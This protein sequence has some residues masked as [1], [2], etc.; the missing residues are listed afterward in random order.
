MIP[1]AETMAVTVAAGAGPGVAVG[2][3]GRFSVSCRL[4]PALCRKRATPGRRCPHAGRGL[5]P[6]LSGPGQSMMAINFSVS[7]RNPW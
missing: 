6:Y 1:G 4:L 3:G 2:A 7:C 5:A